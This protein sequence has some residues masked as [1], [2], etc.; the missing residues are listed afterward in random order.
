VSPSLRA[1]VGHSLAKLGDPRPGVGLGPDTDQPDLMW[2]YVPPGPFTMGSQ[3][4]PMAWEDEKPQHRNES[5]TE[6]YLISRY[7]V[8][9]AQFAAFVEAGGYLEQRYWTEAGWEWK[10]REPQR[11][12]PYDHGEPFNLLNHPVVGVTWYEAV[13]FCQWLEEQLQVEK[14]KLRVWPH[15]ELESLRLNTSTSRVQLPTEAEWEKAAR[16]EDGRRYPWGEESDQ[17]RANFDEAE[18][19][20]T[21]AVGCFP[22][23]ASPYGAEDLGGN[24][25]EWTRSLWGERFEEPFKYPHNLVYGQ[26]NSGGGERTLRVVRGGA[27]D[28][29]KFRVRCATRNG[30]PPYERS[31]IIGFRVVVLPVC[32]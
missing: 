18:I 23:G 19:G 31:R 12:K 29:E 32:L 16:G 3:E 28:A 17:N 11:A 5:I 27:F 30:F 4:D 22:G 13:A 25:W 24:V 21:S 20:A 1:K 26:E 2:C 9:N 6:G 14:S 15:G 10:E 8:T 7:P